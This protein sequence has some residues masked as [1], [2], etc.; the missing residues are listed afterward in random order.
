M[1]KDFKD[2]GSTSKPRVVA[3]NITC[4]IVNKQF[5]CNSRFLWYKWLLSLLQ[6]YVA[7]RITM[8]QISLNKR[9]K[10]PVFCLVSKQRNVFLIFRLFVDR[11]LS[12]IR[13]T[14][15]QYWVSW[16]FPRT[17][18][19]TVCHEKRIYSANLHFKAKA[20]KATQLN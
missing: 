10:V 9:Y 8:D 11:S 3:E 1:T 18:N 20:C 14:K 12:L 17:D 6:S 5:L 13:K 4:Q 2:C 19:D 16:G 7:T 15:C